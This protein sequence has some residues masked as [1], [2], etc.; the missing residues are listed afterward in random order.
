VLL[1]FRQ[2]GLVEHYGWLT[3]QQLLDAVAIAALVLLILLTT[4]ISSAWIVLGGAVLGLAVR[5][6]GRA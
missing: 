1:A 3:R 6:I 2:Q 4:R 5:A